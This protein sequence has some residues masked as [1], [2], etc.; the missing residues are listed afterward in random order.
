LEA[1]KT[2]LFFIPK[3]HHLTAMS[4]TTAWTLPGSL[5]APLP[6]TTAWPFWQQL[7]ENLGF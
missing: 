3:Q 1:P 2:V 4:S 5:L 6:A 7:N